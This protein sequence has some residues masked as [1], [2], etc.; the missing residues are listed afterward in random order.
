MGF[1]AQTLAPTV[2]FCSTPNSSE[3]AIWMTG[4]GPS[5][6]ATDNIYVE[7]GNGPKLDA[8]EFF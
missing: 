4:A 5:V 6:D 3:G 8:N 1:D 2:T 7:T